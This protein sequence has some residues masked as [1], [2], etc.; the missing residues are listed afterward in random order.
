M[1]TPTSSD[2][3]GGS[4]VDSVVQVGYRGLGDALGGVGPRI[5]K[6]HSAVRSCVMISARVSDVV[7]RDYRSTYQSLRRGRSRCHNRE[8]LA[9]GR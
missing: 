1:R 6:V 3:V 8:L 5:L 4:V 2:I 9:L 7:R